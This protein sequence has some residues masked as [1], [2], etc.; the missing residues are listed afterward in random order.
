MLATLGPPPSG[1]GWAFELKWD[2]VRA[3]TYLTH[4][5]VRVLSR[6][7]LDVTGQ[8]PE[9]AEAADLLPDRDAIVD[10]EIV[11]L[12]EVG[13]ASFARLQERMHVAHP[14][15]TLVAAVPVLYQVFDLLHLDG[16][17]TLDLPYTRRR[18]LL[19]GLGLIGDRVRVP[20]HFADVDGRHVLT[21]AQADGLEGVVGKR[22]T[23]TYQPGRRSRDWV[24]TPLNRT[25]EVVIIGY[26]PGGGR[27]SGTLGSL[28]LAVPDHTGALTYAG[29]VGTGFTAKMLDDLH[30]K[31]EPLRRPTPPAAVPRDHRRGVVWVEPVFVA[32]IQY[33]TRSPDGRFR[34]PSWRGLRPDRSPHDIPP[35]DAAPAAPASSTAAPIA[36]TV[37]GAMLTPDGA[38]R[39]EAVHTG[40]SHWYRVIHGDN[41]IDW[42]TIADVELLLQQ[43]GVGLGD[44]HDADPAA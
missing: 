26:K 39:V 34:H 3:V 43:A 9:L 40:T 7:G 19:T 13:H 29:G 16:E 37:D 6:N 33:R 38:W 22:L 42:L 32:E 5:T 36:P 44:L 14:S 27:R 12:D 17:Q 2:G 4:G 28:A 11:A 8:Y 15:P 30:R 1:P 18:D 23:S 21:A 35:P 24:K 10:G 41:T 20:A 31:L 25:Q